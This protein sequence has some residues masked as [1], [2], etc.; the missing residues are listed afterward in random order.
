MGRKS[1]LSDEGWTKAIR[2]VLIDGETV[3]SVA[4]SLGID[5]ASLRRK[6]KPNKSEGANKAKSLK[7]LAIEKVEAESAL[8]QISEEISELPMASQ[9]IVG[10]LAKKLSN[11][12]SYLATSAEHGALASSKLNA[13]MHAEVQR[14]QDGAQE[15][16]LQGVS[17]LN[18][19]SIENL[20]G[21]GALSRLA[22]SASEIGLNLLKA[23]K[24][25]IDDLN[26]QADKPEPKQIVFT[27]QDA[28]T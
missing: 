11:I 9:R 3:N 12:S 16:I 25:A 23:N 17:P 1:A 10:D 8:S 28:R 15:S 4:K 27:V 26:K 5:E 2:R 22:N 24:E 14:L 18:S 21:I 7:Q 19:E 20:K 6:I 13:I